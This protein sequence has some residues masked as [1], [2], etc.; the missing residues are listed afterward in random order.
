MGKLT[1]MEKQKLEKLAQE[2]VDRYRVFDG[3]AV[4]IISLAN[5]EGFCVG[6]AVMTEGTD[7]I[8]AVDKKAESL[9]G[10]GANMVIAVRRGMETSQKRFIIAHELGHYLLRSNP[11]EPIFAMRESAHGRS[12]EENEVD[13]LA[14]CLLMPRRQFSAA[15]AYE[16]AVDGRLEALDEK[17]REFQLAARLSK[18]FRV[19]ELAA[20]RRIREVRE[21]G[22][23]A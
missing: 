8:I 19:P 12:Q 3:D 4:K 21:G 1:C 7:G 18:R 11:E 15:V 10:S 2:L 14:A 16:T 23:G 9:L 20:L 17:E 13:Y 5:Q 22:E 6:E